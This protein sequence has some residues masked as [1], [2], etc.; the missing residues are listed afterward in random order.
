MDNFGKT[1]QLSLPYR[2][3]RTGKGGC[4]MARKRI[5][6]HRVVLCKALTLMM[7]GRVAESKKQLARGA[8][9]IEKFYKNRETD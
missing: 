4:I 5:E 7:Q 9:L 2:G 8:I 3:Y 1:V 6:P